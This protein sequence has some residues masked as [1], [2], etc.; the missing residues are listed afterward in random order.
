MGKSC[1]RLFISLCWLLLL[2][3]LVIIQVLIT[4]NYPDHLSLSAWM[5]FTGTVQC[6]VVAFLQT[7]TWKPGKLTLFFN[8]ELLYMR[9]PTR[10]TGTTTW[11]K[12]WNWSYATKS[13]ARS[14]DATT[15]LYDMGDM[16]PRDVAAGAM[17]Q[18]MPITALAFALAN[19]P[20]EQ[21]SP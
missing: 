16:L 12:V 6:G 8:L 11:W 4:R 3:L 1:N 18:P 21:Q 19:A 10:P 5:C 13:A 15:V 2:V 7:H 9:C 20:L 14:N 17:L